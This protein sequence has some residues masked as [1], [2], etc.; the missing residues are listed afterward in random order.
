LIWSWFPPFEAA[1][2]K[3]PLFIAANTKA[4]PQLWQQT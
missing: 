4:W 3:R 2:L 1:P